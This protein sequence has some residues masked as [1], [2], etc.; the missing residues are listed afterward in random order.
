MKQHICTADINRKLGAVKSVGVPSVQ[1]LLR[2]VYFAI[3]S[4]IVACLGRTVQGW[5]ELTQINTAF[6]VQQYTLQKY[7]MSTFIPTNKVSTNIIHYKETNT[8]RQ[9]NSLQQPN[10]KYY[11]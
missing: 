11:L 8:V 1:H 5:S 3:R 6:T 9:E 4:V 2:D 7:S 10:L